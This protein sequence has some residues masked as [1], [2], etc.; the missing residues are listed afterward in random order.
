M[1]GVPVEGERM[2]D[3]KRI[4]IEIEVPTFDDLQE[5]GEVIYCHPEN[6]RGSVTND[7]YMWRRRQWRVPCG[8]IDVHPI[9]AECEYR[10]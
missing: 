2:R 4:G 3:R 5:S 6:M 8:T 9:L 1:D 10:T 7:V